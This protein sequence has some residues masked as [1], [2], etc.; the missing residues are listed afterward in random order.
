MVLDSTVIDPGL[1]CDQAMTLFGWTIW[2]GAMTGSAFAVGFCP[3]ARVHPYP[4]RRHP[5]RYRT[6]PAGCKRPP[7]R[8]REATRFWSNYTR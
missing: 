7:S 2:L 5:P 4:S 6:P 3:V 8:P 1:P